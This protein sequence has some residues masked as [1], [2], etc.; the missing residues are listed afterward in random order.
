MVFTETTSQRKQYPA[1]QPLSENSMN[2][3]RLL[4][5]LK[6]MTNLIIHNTQS[7]IFFVKLNTFELSENVKNEQRSLRLNNGADGYK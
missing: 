4:W 3:C 2:K 1:A 7:Q 5:I 6:N